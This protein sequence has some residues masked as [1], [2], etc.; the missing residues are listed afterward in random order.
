MRNN[1]A[2]RVDLSACVQRQLV[3]P[4]CVS[5]VVLHA[6]GKGLNG[7]SGLLNTGSLFLRTAVEVLITSGDF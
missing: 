7:R 3:S 5:G 2:T 1:L 6:T 4:S